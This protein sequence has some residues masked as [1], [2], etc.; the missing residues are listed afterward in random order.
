V[1]VSVV[2]RIA[3]PL[4][5]A[6][7]GILFATSAGVSRGADLRGGARSDLP[8]LI[9]AEQS[10]ADDTSDRLDRLRQDIEAATKKA[11]ETDRR[12][13]AEQ[14]RS[15]ALELA[16]GTAPVRGPGLG[17]TLDDAPRSGDR[18]LPEN[19]TADDLVVH[20]QDVQA[21]VNALW[22]GGAE[23]MQIMDQR[24]ITT[25]AVR[26]VGNTLI[27]QGRV[28]SPP[29]HVTA[30][31]DPQRLTEALDT[32]PGV[33]LYRYYADTFGLGYQTEQ[34]DDVRL[35]GYDGTLDLLHV[36]GVS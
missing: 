32:S 29:F 13:A 7:A 10:R 22:A 4:A 14:R 3:A 9:R 2:W 1:S 21:V 11:G 31:G 8:D 16:A 12:V 20:Q 25:S 5:F 30:I 15:R 18:V 33:Q 27:L 35:P 36:A 24:V 26:C 23:A 34:L 28:Y 6:T 17:V 19:A